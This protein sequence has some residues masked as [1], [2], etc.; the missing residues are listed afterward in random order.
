MTAARPANARGVGREA[1]C[2]AATRLPSDAPTG[3]G[4]PL[5]SAERSGTVA[6]QPRNRQF[7]TTRHPAH[8][9]S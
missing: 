4:T 9:V 5:T 7:A 2:A 8:G 6:R 1:R 3:H